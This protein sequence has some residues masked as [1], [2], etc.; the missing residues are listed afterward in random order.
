MSKSRPRVHGFFNID[1]PSGMTSH[2]VVDAIRRLVGERKVG[3]TGTLD[4]LATG[5]LVVAVGYATRLVEFMVHHDKTYRVVIRLGIET[6]TYDAEGEVVAEHPL[7]P[8]TVMDIERVLSRFRGSIRQR[9]PAY[10]AIRHRGKRLYEWAREGVQVHP[11]SRDVTIYE[12]KLEAWEPPDVTLYVRCSAGTYIRSLAHDIGRAL[13]TGGHVKA[14]RRL[15]SGPF[16]I[17]DAVPLATLQ[18]ENWRDFLLPLDVAVQ[19][20]P[21]VDLTSEQARR[22]RH[23]QFLA[24]VQVFA[25]GEW[26]RAYV[27]G[28]F[29]AVLRKDP[30]RGVWRPKKVFL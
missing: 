1:K 9:P 18:R 28:R 24:D 17:E 19:D 15:S 16:R 14:L 6:T 21:R 26:A 3:H 29:V 10:A 23:G 27:D 20:W 13:G 11:K 2:D 25:E 4:P 30:A 5:V 7:P 12:L 8:L 22:V